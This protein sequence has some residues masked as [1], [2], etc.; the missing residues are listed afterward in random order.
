MIARAF[1]LLALVAL[2]SATVP[3]APEK[4]TSVLDKFRRLPEGL[5]G[6]VVAGAMGLGTVIVALLIKSIA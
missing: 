5:Q 3:G 1:A 6:L 2:T 4:D